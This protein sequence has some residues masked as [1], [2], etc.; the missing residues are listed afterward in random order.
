MLCYQVYQFQE[1]YDLA[2]VGYA[3]ASALDPTF[4]LAKEKHGILVQYLSD[5]SQMVQTKV[6]SFD[7]LFL[8]YWTLLCIFLS[9]LHCATSVIL[10][11]QLCVSVCGNRKKATSSGIFFGMLIQ[12]RIQLLAD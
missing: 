6:Q 5:V 3:R 7:L 11:F 1:D 4:S 8:I 10:G 2:L 12:W 9:P